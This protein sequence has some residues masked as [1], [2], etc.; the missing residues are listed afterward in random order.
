[1]SA[2]TGWHRCDRS[3][4]PPHP[5]TPPSECYVPPGLT[6]HPLPLELPLSRGVW[7]RAELVWLSCSRP[8]YTAYLAFLFAHGQ[9]WVTV[10]E[11]GT[12]QRSR[13]CSFPHPATGREC[14]Q[15]DSRFLRLLC[16]VP[17]PRPH[18]GNTLFWASHLIRPKL[19]RLSQSGFPFYVFVIFLS[20]FE[21]GLSGKSVCVC[22]FLYL[23]CILGTT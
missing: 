21:I 9:G 7:R 12:G 10:Q 1:M 18:D 6:P 5:P 20:Y 23:V 3:L 14:D 15:Q 4:A 19:L 17:A 2:S 16:L 22:Y 11:R 8:L 13:D